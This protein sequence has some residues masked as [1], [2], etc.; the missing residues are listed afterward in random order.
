MQLSESFILN[1]STYKRGQIGFG[2]ISQKR[3]APCLIPGRW[4]L[5]RRL[6]YETTIRN[7]RR[8]ECSHGDG[9]PVAGS[10][11]SVNESSRRG[12]SI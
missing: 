4:Q 3:K 9:L 5:T 8:D 12:H 7:S 6:P 1:S 10:N 2:C 11:D